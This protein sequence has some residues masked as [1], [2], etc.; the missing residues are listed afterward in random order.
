MTEPILWSTITGQLPASHRLRL[1][2]VECEGSCRIVVHTAQNRTLQCWVETG[3][4]NYCL[5][6][7][8]Q[9]FV[10]SEFEN[11]THVWAKARAS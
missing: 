11:D 9:L 5:M 3:I 1:R 10:L 4:G 6:C 8:A 2:N 7:F